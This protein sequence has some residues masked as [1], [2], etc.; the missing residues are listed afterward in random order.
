MKL[1][2]PSENENN[3]R[4][5][6]IRQRWEGRKPAMFVFRPEFRCNTTYALARAT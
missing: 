4:R 1:I 2:G 5:E 6:T 3:G